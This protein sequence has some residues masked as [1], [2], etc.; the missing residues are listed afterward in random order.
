M[1]RN[2]PANSSVAS[3]SVRDI[4]T[5]RGGAVIASIFLRYAEA[6]RLNHR[7]DALEKLRN[8]MEAWA[9]IASQRLPQKTVMIQVNKNAK[10]KDQSEKRG[11]I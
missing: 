7:G 8:L 3:N 2:G 10:C 5:L 11:L 6:W 1:L 9:F 4:T